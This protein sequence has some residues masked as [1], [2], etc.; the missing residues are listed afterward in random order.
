MIKEKVKIR[1]LTAAENHYLRE[2]LRLA[3]PLSNGT[4]LQWA[5]YVMLEEKPDG[6]D[7]ID[8]LLYTERE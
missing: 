4:N 6:L 3:Q 8:R 5:A 7:F 2:A 1:S